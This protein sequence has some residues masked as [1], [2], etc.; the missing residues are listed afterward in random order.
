MRVETEHLLNDIFESQEWREWNVDED[1]LWKVVEGLNVQGPRSAAPASA[2]LLMRY[3]E[4]L[5]YRE[6]ADR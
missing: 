4:N 6:M 2:V 5:S 3:H 1:A